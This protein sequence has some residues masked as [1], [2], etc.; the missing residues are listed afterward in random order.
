MIWSSRSCT[1]RAGRLNVLARSA[2]DN[3]STITRR[4]PFAARPDRVKMRRC[5]LR[6][7]RRHRAAQAPQPLTPDERRF[8]LGARSVADL[9]APA[10][11]EVG[12]DAVR[13]DYAF[14]RVLVV[15]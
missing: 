8:A 13:L 5:M 3:S 10:A 15:V 9:L 12:R 6:F 7:E 2:F 11:V 4:S 14:A 1:W